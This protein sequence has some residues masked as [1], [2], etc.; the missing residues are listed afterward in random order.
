MIKDLNLLYSFY[1]VSKYESISKAAN[2]LY[3]SQPAV[4]LANKNLEKEIGL[5]LLF[6]K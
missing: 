4:S 5:P 3:I 1:L 2:A 6:S